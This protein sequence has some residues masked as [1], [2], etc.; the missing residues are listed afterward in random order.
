[1]KTNLLILA[2]LMIA[3]GLAANAPAV[4][5]SAPE[6]PALVPAFP[7]AEGY[8]ARATGGRG[9]QVIAVTNLNADGP[10]SLRAACEAGGPRI[11]VFRVSGTIAGDVKIKHDQIT[12]AG[13]TAPGDGITIKGNLAMDANDVVIRYIR[14]RT[15]HAG[16]AL[17][18]RYRKN[19]ILDH[20]SASWSSDEVLSLY[21]NENVTIQWCMITEA[22]AK[23]DG[24]HRF[25]GIWG[26]QNG[27]Y[28]HNLIAHNDS[29]N[30]RWA[31]GCG[32]NDYR[33]NVL[34]NWGYESSYGGEAQQK[35]DRRTPPIPF[36]TINMVGNYYKPGPATRNDV[37][38]RIAKP[39]SRGSGANGSWHVADNYVD[40]SPEVT[41][42][43]W[44]GIHGNAFTRLAAPWEAMP[45][46]QQSPKDAYLAVLDHAGCSLSKRDSIDTRIIEEVRNGTATHG[47]NGIITT[48]DDVGGWPKLQA[49]EAPLD[50]DN[51]GM[52]DDWELRFKLNPQD[53]SN[54]AQDKDKDGYTNV[55][56]YLNGTDPTVFV[57]YT[58]PEN[59]INT[60]K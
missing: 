51:D 13:Q 20:V 24:S 52:P 41:G 37:K 4:E 9:G 23:P 14:V 54:A 5:N 39:S 38:N 55:E 50:S 56:E 1:M 49:A 19:I 26:N 21:H 31:S 15:D 2:L 7:G 25:G 6:P 34:Y 29:R 10:G 27:T 59:N 57:D 16:D 33:N 32:Y 8:G 35:G 48:P 45:I 58:K 22:C 11:V 43:N 28:H 18:G 60:L 12:I 30:P 47:R 44:L 3:T 53:A 17:G 36:S 40:G 42:N 46:R